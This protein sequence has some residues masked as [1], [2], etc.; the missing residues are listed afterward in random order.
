MRGPDGREIHRA[1]EGPWDTWASSARH[2]AAFHKEDQA[3]FATNPG[4]DFVDIDESAGLRL[5]KFKYKTAAPKLLSQIAADVMC[6]QRAALDQA[7]YVC[8]V[9]SGKTAPRNT[10][11]PFGETQQD[12]LGLRGKGKS[13]DIPLEV[14]DA[15]TLFQPWRDGNLLLWA[16]N[17]LTN[18]HKHRLTVTGT[19]SAIHGMEA[20]MRRHRLGFHWSSEAMMPKW[21]LVENELTWASV[22]LSDNEKRRPQLQ[23]FVSFAEPAEL[24]RQPALAAMNSMGETVTRILMAVEDKAL[25]IGL[26]R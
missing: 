2:M 26:L 21:D 1:F 19:G 14:F 12:A 22:P 25:A 13:S 6:N 17:K 4:E 10:H 8:A 23:L 5:Y 3:Y 9:A 16:M 15:M 11:F 24:S 18:A 7:A 20:A